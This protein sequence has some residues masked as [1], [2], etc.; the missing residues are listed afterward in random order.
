MSRLAA[1][2]L[3][4][5]APVACA[6]EWSGYA[7]V[8]S[9]YVSRGVSLLDDGPALQA[10]TE[11]RFAEVVVAG[12]WAAR[13]QR[14]W[15]Y[16]GA[17]SGAVELNAYAGAD[18]ACGG[19]CRARVIA[20]RYLFPGSDAI[21]W[22]EYSA[23]VALAERVGATWSWSPRGLGSRNATRVVDA[24]FS[25]PLTRALSVEVAGGSVAISR[26]DYWFARAGVSYR[27][28]RYVADLAYHVA[29]P[30][31][32]RFGFDEHS[33]RIVLALSTAW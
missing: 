25:Q 24:W 29:D 6:A 26:F 28:D 9:D 16:P 30:E 11:A 4:L 21:E 32:R 14:Q 17:L 31:L 33:S 15:W 2:P 22:T 23:S 27:F 18:F 5:V 19:P 12:A 8:A 7:S 20:S 13:A 1:M 10:G 3:L